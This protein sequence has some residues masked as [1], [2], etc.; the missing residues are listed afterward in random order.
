VRRSPALAGSARGAGITLHPLLD[1]SATPPRITRRTLLKVGIAGG[2]ALLLARWLYTATSVPTP[3]DSRFTALD[4]SAQS[5]VAAIVPVLLDGALPTGRD[6]AAVRA[7]VVSGVDQAIAGLMPAVRK[8]LD[9]LF[10]LLAF[11]PTR[12]LIAGLWSPWPEASPESVAAFLYAWRDS[13]FALLRSG[14]SA[15]HQIV[16]GAWYGNPQA[17]PAIGYPGPPSL[18]IG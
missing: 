8:E 4:A 10:S 5:I 3:P 9:D 14:Y 12:C 13:R 16:L 7:D 1:P 6:A 2:A 15:L 11:A 18:E 17:W